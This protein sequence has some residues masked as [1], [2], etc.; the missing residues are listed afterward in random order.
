MEVS[1]K[2]IL[3]M[4]QK[5]TE[6]IKKEFGINSFEIIC[7][8]PGIGKSAGE[9]TSLRGSLIWKFSGNVIFNN[10]KKKLIYWGRCIHWYD[11]NKMEIWLNQLK[12]SF[13][14][15]LDDL[16]TKKFYID[17]IPKS[18]GTK[19]VYFKEFQPI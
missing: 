7:K 10:N 12:H 1:K 16:K 11:Y 15:S 9:Q 4:V 14:C 18:I 2:D 17:Q 5:F 19:K 8:F 6:T 3:E 13:K